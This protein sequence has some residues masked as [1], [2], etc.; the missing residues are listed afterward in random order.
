IIADA[1]W[2]FNSQGASEYLSLACKSNNYKHLVVTDTQGTI[3]QKA[4]GEEPRGGESLFISL[5]LISEVHLISNVTYDGKTIGRI[6]AIW[7]CDNIYLQVYILFALVM[8][9]GIFHLN[10]R[11]LHSKQMLETKVR[12]RTSALNDLNASLQFEVEEHRQAREELRKSE[13]RF[14]SMF[15]Q[16]A[17]GVAL[18]N[19]KTGDY[20]RVN[21]RYC[22]IVGYNHQEINKLSFQEITHP[23]DLQK[24]LDNMNLLLEGKIQN[25]T[26]EKRYF[27]KDGSLIWVKITVS[28]MRKADEEINFHIA[29]VED[30]TWRKIAEEAVRDSEEKYKELTGSLPQV[31]FETDVTG[32]LTFVNQNAFDLFGYT[33]E[34]FAK[35]LNAIQMIIPE[36][37]DRAL[38]NI[39]KI[40]DGTILDGIEHTALRK[41][42]TTFPVAI[43]SNLFMRDNKPMGLRGL[44]IDLSKSKKMETDLKRRAMAMDQSTETIVITDTKGLITYVN[45]A[46][47]KTTGYSREEAIGKNPSI[48]QSGKQDEMFYHELWQTISRGKTWS[49]RFVNR[50]KDGSEYI[51]EATISPIFSDEGEI[52]NYVAVKRDISDKLK[53]EAQ[54][55][56]AQ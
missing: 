18:C 53:L 34:E 36:E 54:L 11:L 33:E 52:V 44:I 30:I 1:L 19:S 50:K 26:Q 39:Q 10:V 9:Y 15:E 47:E 22:D 23:D 43:H 56:Q 17:V 21:Q 35:G 24:D 25:F 3:F 41:D 40:M 2:N 37:H 45:P 20:V 48:L 27:R 28:P 51:E 29:I 31:V 7:Y 14:R 55:Q 42:G 4:V 13:E 12:E 6:E 32:N 16:A 46:F 49:G 8:I 38:E 5:N